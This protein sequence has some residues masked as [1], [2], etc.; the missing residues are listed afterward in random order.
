MTGLAFEG[1]MPTEQWVFGMDPMVKDDS[2]PVAFR[3]TCLTL[4]PIAPFVF[5]VLLVT[6][7]TVARCVFE[8][9]SEMALFAFNGL[10]LPHKRKTRLVVIERRL[11]P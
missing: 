4:V 6:G 11:L 9:R 5:I 3:V 1:N 2:F 8:R 7:I 10:V